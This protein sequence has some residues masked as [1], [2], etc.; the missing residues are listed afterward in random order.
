MK[1]VV[2]FSLTVFSALGLMK[3]FSILPFNRFADD[4]FGYLGAGLA[5]NFWHSQVSTYL[6]WTGRFT[7][8]FI[9]S[10]SG[11]FEGRQGNPIVYSLITFLFLLLA[12]VVFYSRLLGLKVWNIRVILFS[13]VS[14]IALYILTP[15]KAESWYWMTG[16]ATYLWPIIFLALGIANIFA[17]KVR[18]IDYI[19]S[20]VFIFL[21]VAGNEAFGLLTV[22]VLVGLAICKILIK[23]PNKLLLTMA[24]AAVISFAIVYFAPGNVARA[25]SGGS[26]PMSWFGELC[27]RPTNRARLYLFDYL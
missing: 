14:F 11:I 8:T 17:K 19:L 2:S 24:S 15:N 12:F 26:N 25:S 3:I 22:A 27:L 20:F 18:K 23:R 4:D 16:S 1:K 5:N 13:C 6:T 9:L 10:L 7:S 21:S